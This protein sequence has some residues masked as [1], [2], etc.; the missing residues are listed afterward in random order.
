MDGLYYLQEFIIHN[1][2]Y[3]NTIQTIHSH[4]LTSYFPK[5]KLL[6]KLLYYKSLKLVSVSKEIEGKVTND[7]GFKNITQIYNP[8]DLE[9]I[10]SNNEINPID[11]E[12][13][14]GV[15]SM[16]KN[17]KQFDHLIE[18]Y[19][20]SILPQNNIKLIILGDGKLKENWILL[21]KKLGQE[22]N[23][24]F[25]GNIENPFSYYKQAFL[26]CLTSKYEGLPMVLL[27]SLAS[28]TPVV[29]YDCHSGPSEIIQH[30]QNGLLVENQNKTAFIEALNSMIEDKKLYLHCKSNAKSSIGNYNV[31]TI[32]NQWLQLFKDLSK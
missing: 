15:G 4:K 10:E 25:K 1:F 5:N 20:N 22:Q 16:N 2:I 18:C 23:I 12:Y 24:I 13:I 28:G 30:N 17:I 27:E 32:G 31:D 11:F 14:L 21:A 8:I 3:K 19:S 7:Y 9:L 29:A 26:T 6:A